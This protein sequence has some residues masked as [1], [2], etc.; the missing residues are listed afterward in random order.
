MIR[1]LLVLGLAQAFSQTPRPRL[2]RQLAASEKSVELG[3]YGGAGSVAACVVL[4]SEATLK[5]TGCGLPAGPFGLLGALE[6]VSYLAIV[7]ILGAS[8]S[9]KVSTG[10][11]LPA[12]PLG[13][14]GAAEGLAY[15]AGAL[16][17]VVLGLQIADYG[18]V[19]NAVP[20]E[21]GVCS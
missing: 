7:G 17:I 13:L 3:V 15:I 18:Y 14:L 20:V 21:G 16:G 12:G 11:G 6:G 4:W 19:P 1:V 9:S 2:R 10:R 5:T 8:I